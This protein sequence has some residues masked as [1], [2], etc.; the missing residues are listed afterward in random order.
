M[1][2]RFDSVWPWLSATLPLVLAVLGVAV[3][4][5]PPLTDEWKYVWL[6]IF[7]LLGFAAVLATRQEQTSTKRAHAHLLKSVTG[8]DGYCYFIVADQRG[9]LR[10]MSLILM[11][12]GQFP[13]YDMTFSVRRNPT[14]SMSELEQTLTLLNQNLYSHNYGTVHKGG[15]IINYALPEQPGNDLS[16]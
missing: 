3:T 4:F 12:E 10:P 7:V 1:W 15:R 8:G 16:P 6:A 2:A 9:P 5:F 14:K 13:L 11:N